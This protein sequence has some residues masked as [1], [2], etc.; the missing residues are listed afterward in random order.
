MSS[1]LL[2]LVGFIVLTFCSCEQFFKEVSEPV[3]FKIDSFNVSTDYN[4]E[5]SDIHDI[6]DAWVYVD[7]QLQGVYELPAKFPV[8]ATEGEHDILITPGIKL[9][10]IAAT[11]FDYKVMTSYQ[12]TQNLTIGDT[13]TFNPE[14]SYRENA[15]FKWL[16]DFEQGGESWIKDESSDTTMT[17]QSIDSLAF[18]GDGYGEIFMSNE[19][20]FFEIQSNVDFLPPAVNG[21]PTFLEINHRSITSSTNDANRLMAIG[22]IAYKSSAIVQTEPFIYI[23]SKDDWNKTY[24]NLT[25]TLAEH[26]DAFLFKVYIGLA[27]EAGSGEVH[28]LIDNIKLVHL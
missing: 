6:S 17:I 14:V 15:V 25:A 23:N 2:L 10:G 22:I 21:T 7:D 11:R 13:I 27:K 18:E 4:E 1:K 16:E 5:G 3:Y 12:V 19:M 26:S 24:V 20:T 8:I 28:T 9:N